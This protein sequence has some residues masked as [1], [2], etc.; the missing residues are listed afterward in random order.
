[1]NSMK[2]A[3]AALR[4]RPA[5][6]RP[7]LQRRAYADV[8]SDKIQLSLTLPHQ[9]RFESSPAVASTPKGRDQ[10]L[11]IY[12]TGYLQVAGC[13]CSLKIEK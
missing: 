12:V 3:R 9:V 1:M 11:T 5:L 2:F 8:A 13:V 4:A 6:A 10:V 7:A